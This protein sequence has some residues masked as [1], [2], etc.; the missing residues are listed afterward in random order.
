MNRLSNSKVGDKLAVTAGFSRT[1]LIETVER[2]TKT[3]VITERH[4]FNLEGR[5]TGEAAY[6]GTLAKPATDAV[7][8]AVRINRAKKELATLVVN[9]G[10]LALVESLLNGSAA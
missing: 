10:N 4:R 3:L 8:L 9:E 7:I 5:I 2:V 1:V 6:Y